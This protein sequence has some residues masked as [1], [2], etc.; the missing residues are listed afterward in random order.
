MLRL[1][2]NRSG[3]SIMYALDSRHKPYTNGSADGELVI[4]CNESKTDDAIV[5]T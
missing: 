2:S 1:V 3:I 4:A 5:V